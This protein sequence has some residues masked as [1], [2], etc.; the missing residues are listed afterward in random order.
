MGLWP[1]LEPKR[2][3]LNIWWDY[4]DPTE[5]SH[6]R[7][8]GSILREI[9][10][11]CPQRWGLP[12]GVKIPLG[13]LGPVHYLGVGTRTQ[14]PHFRQPGGHGVAKFGDPVG[15]RGAKE[16][17]SRPRADRG[18]HPRAPRV[19]SREFSHRP[20]WSTKVN[21]IEPYITQMS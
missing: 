4:Q 2:S 14:G 5:L 6:R 1:L 17:M 15:Y 21:R 3:V 13:G 7:P 16:R 10:G 19:N 20:R 18:T 11:N 8:G 12:G 9:R